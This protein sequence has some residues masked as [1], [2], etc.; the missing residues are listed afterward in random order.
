[1]SHEFQ[2]NSSFSSD[3]DI[4]G[5]FLEFRWGLMAISE[6]PGEFQSFL[7]IV[8]TTINQML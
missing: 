8:T 2:V 4:F 1:L 5:H 6:N 3:I 7:M